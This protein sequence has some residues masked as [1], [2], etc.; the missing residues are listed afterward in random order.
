M[1]AKARKLVIGVA[2]LVA[3]ALLVLQ[4]FLLSINAQ[5]TTTLPSS[6]TSVVESKGWVIKP[7]LTNGLVI[8]NDAV[9]LTVNITINNTQAIATP[10]PFDQFINITEQELAN[11]LPGLR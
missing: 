6:N 4:P 11:A 1:R 7:E 8:L 9:G 5:T 2:L 3:F 10:A